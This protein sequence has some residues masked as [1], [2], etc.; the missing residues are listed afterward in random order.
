MVKAGAW[1]KDAV[2]LHR[3][4]GWD[5]VTIREGAPFLVTAGDC[6]LS[7]TE[8]HGRVRVRNSED[9]PEWMCGDG[10]MSWNLEIDKQIAY[11]V[12][13]GA[14]KPLRESG[15]FEMFWHAEGM[16]TAYS[17]EVIFNG[18][19]YLVDPASC[20]GYADK[21][22]GRDFTSPWVWLSSNNLVSA[23]SGKRLTNSVF[24]IGGG[25][26]KIGHLALNR[27]LLGA[28]FY[29]GES[30][31][32]NFSKFWTLTRT[33]FSC[34][35]TETQVIWH[36]EQ[37]TPLHRMVTD[38][39]CEK[40]EMLLI[41]YEAPDGTKRHNRLWNGGNG[42]GTVKLYERRLGK[43]RLI[44]IVQAENVGCEYGEYSTGRR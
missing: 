11:N 20:Y 28:F 3:F 14:S 41:N 9:H 19:K 34:E 12:G 4:F 33:E 44:D 26:P 31:E 27:K 42:K 30:Y 39:T 6:G 36:V 13:Y 5:N 21:N 10:E 7:E 35:E 32:F 40:K 17:G 8:T 1:G 25:R 16:K 18:E 24:N 15:A 22:W 38:I 29:E 23:L 37:E 2:Q 43:E